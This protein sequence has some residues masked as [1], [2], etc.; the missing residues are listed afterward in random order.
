MEYISQFLGR[1]D[2]GENLI[3][4]GH[5]DQRWVLRPSVGRHYEGP[6]S[7]VIECEMQ[8]LADFKKRAIPYLRTQPKADIEWHCFGNASGGG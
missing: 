8:V 1:V 6:W 4:R 5:S 2:L 7:N 3:Y